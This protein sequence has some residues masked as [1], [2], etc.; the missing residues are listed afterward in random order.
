MVAHTKDTRKKQAQIV[1]GIVAAF[2]VS[3]A[4]IVGYNKLVDVNQQEPE[5]MKTWDLVVPSPSPEEVK[6]KRFK[7]GLASNDATPF[8]VKAP[9]L[10]MT[11]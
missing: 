7:M 3:A 6:F 11:V 1:G 8:A 9:A 2:A 4:T 5:Q 10:T